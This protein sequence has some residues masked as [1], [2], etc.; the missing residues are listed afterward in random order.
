MDSMTTSPP[1]GAHLPRSPR[2][3]N[4][5]S[6]DIPYAC[7]VWDTRIR[8][9]FVTFCIAAGAIVAYTTR[10]FINGDAVAYF[11]MADAFEKQRWGDML[12]LHYSPGYA[13]LIGLMEQVFPA[14][15]LNELFV[16]KVLN[17][18]CY[19]FSLV[20]LELLLHQLKTDEEF[21][22]PNRYPH[23]GW[24]YFR[25]AAYGLFLVL[26]LVYVRIQVV[27][28]D[29][30]EFCFTLLVAAVLVWIKKSAE[31]VVKF[32]VLGV[33]TGIGYLCKAPFFPMSAVFFVLA[34]LYG[35]SFRRG[36]TRVLVA[37][38]VFLVIG[39]PLWVP[40]SYRLGRFS[41]GE[42]GSFNYTHFVSGTGCPIHLP[43]KV[44][45]R[46][47]VDVS[48]GGSPAAT[49]PSGFD[50]SYWNEGVKP[51]FDLRAQ[52]SV[53]ARSLVA[54]IGLNPWLYLCFLV[55]VCLQA[56]AGASFSVRLRP[57]ALPVLLGT[58]AVAGTGL[59][60]LVLVEARY[61]APYVFL[62]L[63]AILLWPRYGSIRPH[64]F[65]TAGVGL[66][67]IT[68]FLITSVIVSIWDQT[69]RSLYDS[70]AKQSHR[71]TFLENVAVKDFLNRRGVSRGHLVAILGDPSIGY[72]WARLAGVRA[73][74]T[75]PDEKEFLAVSPQDR[76]GALNALRK[77]QFKVILAA[78]NFA[79][80]LG[81]EG[82]RLV[83]GTKNCFVLFLG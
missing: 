7:R 49:C 59:F 8:W 31:P 79:A 38:I 4:V 56:L 75:I 35:T 65:K 15:S 25:A 53:L 83:P 32:V 73:I 67:V 2:G 23:I 28:P 1:V 57:P 80:E 50:L 63:I 42:S 44:W 29:M 18:F 27:S 70:G 26:S 41:F 33:V 14:G 45:S 12:N 34:A 36:L 76:A 20:A 37:V 48:S 54:L 74:A 52:V 66:T 47:T 71:R 82:W 69:A 72:Y 5:D 61:V 39:S 81:Q 62:G 77:R 3:N 68:V 17:L 40:T 78:G 51:S 9:I 43:D 11:D 22:P 21:A 13:I 19:V 10:H 24:L 55:W 64:A 6:S 60:C 30:L 46:P 58:M 16:A